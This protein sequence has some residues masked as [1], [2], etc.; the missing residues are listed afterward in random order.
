VLAWHAEGVHARYRDTGSCRIRV[1][2]STVWVNFHTRAFR[3]EDR[4]FR[5]WRWC[6]VRRPGDVTDD[7]LERLRGHVA[8]V[9]KLA[10][11]YLALRGS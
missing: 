4:R 7:L 10:D 3:K 2:A 1:G 9:E 11:E 8:S 6:S 5:F